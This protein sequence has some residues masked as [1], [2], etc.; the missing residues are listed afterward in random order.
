MD[1]SRQDKELLLDYCLGIAPQEEV[2]RAE[3]LLASNPR[4][5]QLY[6]SFQRSM[7]PLQ[8]LESGPCPPEWV[9]R[10]VTRLKDAAAQERLEGLLAEQG[11]QKTI[12]FGWGMNFTQIAAIAAMLVFVVGIFIPSFAFARNIYFRNRCQM[13]LARIYDGLSSYSTDHQDRLPAVAMAD[14]SPWWKVGYQ[15][16]E[17]HSNTRPVWLLVRQ[18]YV[19]PGRFICPSTKDAPRSAGFN[20][21]DFNDFPD[22]GYVRYSFRIC[23]DRT[24]ARGRS[25]HPDG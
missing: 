22:K 7:S 9:E 23:C 8:T 1:I 20:P 4:A 14:G 19:E 11:R 17:N 13:Q 18:G 24:K 21:A 2:L 5:A 12:K 25:Q 15:G 16:K 3:S 10:T 6:A